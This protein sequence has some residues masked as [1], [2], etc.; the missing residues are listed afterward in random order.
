[1]GVRSS[2]I[3]RRKRMEITLPTLIELFLATKL[4]EGRSEDRLSLW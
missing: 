2:E 3:L 1:M 4:T